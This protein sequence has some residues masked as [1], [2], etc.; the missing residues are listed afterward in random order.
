VRG[1]LGLRYGAH[2][3]AGYA[4]ADDGIAGRGARSTQASLGFQLWIS[5]QASQSKDT[6]TGGSDLNTTPGEKGGYE[7]ESLHWCVTPSNA[8]AAARFD[9]EALGCLSR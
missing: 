7:E 3:L 4:L 6:E 5:P 8:P 9:A 1:A 2:A